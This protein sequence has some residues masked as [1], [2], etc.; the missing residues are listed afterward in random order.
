MSATSGKKKAKVWFDKVLENNR[1]AAVFA[2]VMQPRGKR[3]R[4]GF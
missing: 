4:R 2:K 1:G 3:Q